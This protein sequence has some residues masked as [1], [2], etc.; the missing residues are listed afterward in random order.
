M[1]HTWLCGLPVWLHQEREISLVS[2]L[3][4]QQRMSTRQNSVVVVNAIV[5]LTRNY[6]YTGQTAVLELKV[7]MDNS[8]IEFVS[9]SAFGTAA[10]PQASV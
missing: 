5:G 8:I 10:R 9:L 6:E 1:A 7:R 2:F 4:W 3:L